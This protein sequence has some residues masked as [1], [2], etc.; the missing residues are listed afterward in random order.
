MNYFVPFHRYVFYL[1]ASQTFP[2]RLLPVISKAVVQ[3]TLKNDN[4]DAPHFIPPNPIFYLVETTPA[5]TEI[6]AVYATDSDNDGI[7]YS[8]SHE[9]FS[10]DPAT[11]VLRL[12]K[13]FISSPWTNPIMISVTAKDDGSSCSGNDLCHSKSNSTTIQIIVILENRYSPYFSD[14]NLC[15][16]EISFTE[17]K[18]LGST[19]ASFTVVDNDR[20]DNGRISFSFPS[21][22]LQTTGKYIMQCFSSMKERFFFPVR[23]LRNTAYNDFNLYPMV[24]SGSTRTVELRTNKIFDYDEPGKLVDAHLIISNNLYH[25]LSH[26]RYDS[27]LVS[28]Y[29]RYRSR[30]TFTTR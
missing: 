21:S 3:I 6:G 14:N 24:Q 4:L 16:G 9:R 20:E 13:D 26:S 12:E 27:S 25:T 11:G 2:D 7:E 30:Y 10:I 8:I 15:G 19:I 17:N 23:G 28:K 5:M 1:T 18:T 29:Y 22:E